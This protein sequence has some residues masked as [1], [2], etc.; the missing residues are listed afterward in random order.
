MFLSGTLNVETA[1]APEK[2]DTL[3]TLQFCEP[4]PVSFTQGFYLFKNLF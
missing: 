3:N 2:L 1:E 4:F